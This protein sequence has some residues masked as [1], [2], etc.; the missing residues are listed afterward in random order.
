MGTPSPA[1][2]PFTACVFLLEKERILSERGIKA[3]QWQHGPDYKECQSTCKRQAEEA[4]HS[5]SAIRTAVTIKKLKTGEP[6]PPR[7]SPLLQVEA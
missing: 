5:P 2:V 7:S 1:P 4:P 6:R 3:G